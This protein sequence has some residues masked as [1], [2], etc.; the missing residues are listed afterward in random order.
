MTWQSYPR[1]GERPDSESPDY[2]VGGRRRAADSRDDQAPDAPTEPL[3]LQ[4]ST[5][6]A[7]SS[8]T[9]SETGQAPFVGVPRQGRGEPATQPLRSHGELPSARAVRELLAELQVTLS[10]GGGRRRAPDP[11]A[12]SI[13]EPPEQDDYP[14][15]PEP[16][17]Y[18]TPPTPAEPDD[19]PGKRRKAESPDVPPPPSASYRDEAG[20][21]PRS[22]ELP[23]GRRSAELPLAPPSLALPEPPELPG[24]RELPT[25]PL[26]PPSLA[27][28]EAPELPGGH[29]AVEPPLLPPSLA[30]P[31][32]PELPASF[33]QSDSGHAS[34][35]W[36]G[37]PRTP[38]AAPPSLPPEPRPDASLAEL[39]SD[40]LAAYQTGQAEEQPKPDA[41]GR[42]RSSGWTPMDADGTNG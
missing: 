11:E 23:G 20:L 42:H 32:P 40:A 15:V 25:A 6:D 2:E 41:S 39:L 30:L 21:L 8:L 27:L 31:G 29:R 26:V 14:T 13:P 12:G 22:P 4:Q 1:A 38:G 3:G 36:R 37:F 7:L 34:S 28:P 19:K 9:T 5:V 16:D 33:G 18:P 17:D 24:G 10:E 35:E